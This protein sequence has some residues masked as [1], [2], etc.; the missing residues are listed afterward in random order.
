MP[1]E[2]ANFIN[3]LVVTN[4]DGSVDLVST[5]D[6]HVRLLKQV[7]KN[8]FPNLPSQAVNPTATEFNKLVGLTGTL[9]QLEVQQAWTRQQNFP[10]QTLTD[11]ATIA[12]DLQTQQVAR[13]TLGGNRLLANPTNIVAGGTY[14]L[15]V[16]QDGTGSR[17]LSY[18]TAYDF[19]LDG[20]PILSTGGGKYDILAF[21]GNLA[22]NGLVGSFKLGF[23]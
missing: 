5:L 1:L 12:W 23:G 13:V 4:P 14:I 18:G 8:Q 20:V 17:T 19:G 10:L 7:L 6:N 22:G 3:D 16:V 2:S 11:G 15:Y 9:A 21:L